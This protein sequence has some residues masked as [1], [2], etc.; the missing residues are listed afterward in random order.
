MRG[1]INPQS[2]MFHYFSVDSRVP[3]DRPLRRV[4]KLAER[5]LR[6]ISSELDTLCSTT[7]RPSIAPERL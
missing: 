3:S 4:K 5:A 7:A 2:T 6:A 1:Q